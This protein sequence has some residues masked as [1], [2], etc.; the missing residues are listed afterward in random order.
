[1]RSVLALLLI[2]LS[3]SFEQDLCRADDRLRKC[4][5]CSRAVQME[6]LTKVEEQ[7]CGNLVYGCDGGCREIFETLKD[8]FYFTWGQDF[9]DYRNL[10]FSDDFHAENNHSDH[11]MF[12]RFIDEGQFW[13]KDAADRSLIIISFS[14]PFQRQVTSLSKLYQRQNPGRAEWGWLYPPKF[15]H[16]VPPVP[17]GRLFA[18]RHHDRHQLSHLVLAHN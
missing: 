14:G 16:R 6:K 11:P 13:L 15:V 10:T 9:C 1:M 17:G 5:L 3:E 2:H 4:S 12:E 7:I 8:S 18:A